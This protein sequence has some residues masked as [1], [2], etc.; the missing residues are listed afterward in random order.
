[1]V[2]QKDKM[3]KQDERIEQAYDY[4]L[5]LSISYRFMNAPKRPPEIETFHWHLHSLSSN[6]GQVAVK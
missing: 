2:F 3:L 6:G 1:L 4:L 5:F